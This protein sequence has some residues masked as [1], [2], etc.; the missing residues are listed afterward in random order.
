MLVELSLDG[1]ITFSSLIASA[2]PADTSVAWVVPATVTDSARVRV[3][4]YDVDNLSGSDDSNGNF[5]IGTVTGMPGDHLPTSWRLVRSA[6]SPAR[7]GA[8]WRLDVVGAERVQAEIYDVR[9]VR[10]ARLVDAR[11]LPGSYELRW[12]GR[13]VA[14]HPA[15]AGVYVCRV[16]AGTWRLTARLVLAR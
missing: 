5:I 8:Q 11:L 6:A 10:I 7:E 15:S 12:D 9:G 2:G 1:G 14:G 4:A 3:I 13:T 16:M